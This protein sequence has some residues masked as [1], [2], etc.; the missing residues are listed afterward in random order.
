MGFPK[1]QK[2]LGW[3][4]LN[5]IKTED[6]FQCRFG[7]GF[8]ISMRFPFADFAISALSRRARVSSFFADIT[9]KL[10]NRL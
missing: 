2:E 4:N 6:I 3:P 10:I 9:Q 1:K 5:G 7:F 8:S